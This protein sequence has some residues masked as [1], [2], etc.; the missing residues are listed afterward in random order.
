MF[1][2][3]EG[4]PL[5]QCTNLNTVNIIELLKRHSNFLNYYD[6]F[7]ENI[8]SDTKDV[9]KCMIELTIGEENRKLLDD[10]N[11]ENFKIFDDEN[12]EKLLRTI[13]WGT[14]GYLH[15]SIVDRLIKPTGTFDYAKLANP[16]EDKY[17]VEFSSLNGNWCFEIEHLYYDSDQNDR[18]TILIHIFHNRSG[19]KGDKYGTY[20]ISFSPITA[21]VY[22]RSL[23]YFLAAVVIFLKKIDNEI[24]SEKRYKMTKRAYF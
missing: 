12:D 19:S 7:A 9:L 6:W 18:Q 16:E 22:P 10:E 14:S 24:K 8:G 13:D 15:P 4:I 11:F 23:D 20:H 21:D 3:F 17:C 2:K 1:Y 5:D